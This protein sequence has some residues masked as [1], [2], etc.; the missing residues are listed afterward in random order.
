MIRDG[1]KVVAAVAALGVAGCGGS[2]NKA[3]SYSDF[4]KK[5]DEVCATANAKV[6]PI[7]T[8]ITGKASA[9]APVFDQLIPELQT[10]RDNFG[11]LKPPDALKANYDNF[12]SITDQQIAKAKEAQAAAKSGDQAGYIGVIKATQSLAQ[13]SNLEASKLGAAECAK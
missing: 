1:L 11:K 2:S 5:A 7:G 13:Q 9:D 4:G 8:K 10:A 12:L 3:L 6:K